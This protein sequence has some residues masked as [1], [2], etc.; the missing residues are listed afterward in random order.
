M[1]KIL[2]TLLTIFVFTGSNYVVTANGFKDVPYNHWGYDAILWTKQNGIL[3]GNNE[4]FLPNAKVSR[5]E[6]AVVSNVFISFFTKTLTVLITCL[7]IFPRVIGP[8]QKLVG[9]DQRI[10]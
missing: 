5:A 7:Q 1:K 9:C 8:M 3:K 2:L 4:S 6:L 10:L